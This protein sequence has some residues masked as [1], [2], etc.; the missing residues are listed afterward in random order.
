MVTYEESILENTRKLNQLEKDFLKFTYESKTPQNKEE[1]DSYFKQ[2]ALLSIDAFEVRNKIL[3]DFHDIT[4]LT[5]HD[6][7]VVIT[8]D[9]IRNNDHFCSISFYEGLADLFN[10]NTEDQREKWD[11]SIEEYLHTTFDELFDDFHSGFSVYGYYTAKMKIGPI[12]TSFHVPQNILGYFDE[13]KET[14]AFGQ[15]RSTIALCRA[16]LEM[17]LFDKLNR[18]KVFK[19]SNPKITSIDEAKKDNLYEYIHLAKWKRIIN[20]N[21][22]EAAHRVRKSSNGILHIKDRESKPTEKVT[23][24]IIFDTV[25]LIESL[26]RQ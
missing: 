18:L 2:A 11:I 6:P 17:T 20:H 3:A 25:K 24:E 19:S 13:I 7:S 12:I 5:I 16:L 4:N 1:L 21:D 8:L 10:R 22:V 23:F 15:Y 9:K 14:F 26:Y